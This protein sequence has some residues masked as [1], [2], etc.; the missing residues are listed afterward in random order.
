MPDEEKTDAE[1]RPFALTGDSFPKIVIR[2]D[3]GRR[4]YDDKGI[5]N[6]SVTDFLLDKEII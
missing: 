4:W 2:K 6:I 3:V 1:L 5:L